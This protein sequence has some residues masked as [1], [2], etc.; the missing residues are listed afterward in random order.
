MYIYI[1]TKIYIYIYIY[2]DI[3][4]TYNI[5]IYSIYIYTHTYT[6][7]YTYAHAHELT[8]IQTHT[9]TNNYNNKIRSC[10]Y[11]RI[12]RVVLSLSS[13]PSPQND[14]TLVVQNVQQNSSLHTIPLDPSVES[15]TKERYSPKNIFFDIMVCWHTIHSLKRIWFRLAKLLPLYCQRHQP[16]NGNIQCWPFFLMPRNVSKSQ[17]N[18]FS[19]C[20]DELE[21]CFENTFWR[22]WEVYYVVHKKE[23]PTQSI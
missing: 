12:V 15:A 23:I 13:S 1:Y 20:W 2:V 22:C 3:H 5:D 7:T 8:C 19:T 18:H 6:Y 16:T 21:R 17:S 14:T 9:H 10:R 11:I 4:T